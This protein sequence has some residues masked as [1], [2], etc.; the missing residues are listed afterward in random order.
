ML[1]I[2]GV[3]NNDRAG[4]QLGSDNSYIFGDG[5]NIGV[6]TTTPSEKLDVNGALEVTGGIKSGSSSNKVMWRTFTEL[7]LMR[8][9]L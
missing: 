3:Q 7:Q 6:G 4:V 8:D 9:S 1:G 2:Y 5:G